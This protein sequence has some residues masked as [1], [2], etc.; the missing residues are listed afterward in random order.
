MSPLNLS[1]IVQRDP[2]LIFTDMDGETVML[3]IEEGNYY[4]LS[5]IAPDLWEW[6]EKPV[7]IG[8]LV[9]KV[10]DTFEVDEE[11]CRADVL[12]HLAELR[13]RALIQIKPA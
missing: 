6:M 7:S 1:S 9:Q 3:N 4:G 11:T 10:A 12:A 13:D 5:G 8:T 2:D